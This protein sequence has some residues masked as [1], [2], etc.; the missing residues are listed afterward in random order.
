MHD[1]AKMKS[2][3]ILQLPYER[4]LIRV[5]LNLTIVLKI[6]DLIHNELWS[7]EETFLNYQQLKKQIFWLTALEKRLNALIF[8]K[9][10]DTTKSMSYEA[11]IIKAYS[12]NLGIKKNCMDVYQAININIIFLDIVEGLSAC[13]KI[14]ICLVAL[15]LGRSTQQLFVVAYELS[16]ACGI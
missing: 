5:F 4:N 1:Q 16:G 9:E 2:P 12:Q 11:V 7:W 14:F 13:L 3:E 6:Y 15:G 8:S 10:N